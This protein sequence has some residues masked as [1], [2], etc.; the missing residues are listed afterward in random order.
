MATCPDHKQKDNIENLL[1]KE[2]LM[3]FFKFVFIFLKF[4]FCFIIMLAGQLQKF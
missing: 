2:V 3:N 1:K 4:L